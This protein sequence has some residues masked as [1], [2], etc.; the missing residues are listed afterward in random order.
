MGRERELGLEGGAGEWRGKR[1]G[2]DSW[3]SE[4]R[5]VG[6]GD[7]LLE[8]LELYKSYIY[9]DRVVKCSRHVLY[10]LQPS[11]SGATPKPLQGYYR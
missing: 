8:L 7:E 10:C 5:G 2:E 3:L 11:S 4:E 1:G 9:S 6:S